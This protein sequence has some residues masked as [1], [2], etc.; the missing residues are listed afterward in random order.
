MEGMMQVT[1]HELIQSK[2]AV[3]VLK[4]LADVAVKFA[5]REFPLEAK[6]DLQVLIKVLKRLE[7]EAV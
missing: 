7:A 6:Q 3:L 5:E 1:K 4:D 2:R